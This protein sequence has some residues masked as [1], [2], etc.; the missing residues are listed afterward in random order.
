MEFWATGTQP[1][2]VALTN[3]NHDAADAIA[4]VYVIT[5]AHTITN[6]GSHA[7]VTFS[8]KHSI[9]VTCDVLC[10]GLGV[11]GSIHGCMRTVTMH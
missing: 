2:A 9:S 3:G 11:S 10:Y 7:N 5:A 4:P 6:N 1:I 8:A